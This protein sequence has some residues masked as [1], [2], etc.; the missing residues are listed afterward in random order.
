MNRMENLRSFLVNQGYKGMQ[1]FDT[2]NIA[3]DYMETIYQEDGIVVDICRGY[4]Y[5]EIFGLSDE[6][7]QSLDDILDIC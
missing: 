4:C 5:L 2:R 7:Y 1:T 6:E 3:G